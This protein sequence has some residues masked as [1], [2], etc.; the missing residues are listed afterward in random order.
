MISGLFFS[1]TFAATAAIGTVMPQ[2][3]RLLRMPSGMVHE[4]EHQH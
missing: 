3:P 2:K 4:E 1:C